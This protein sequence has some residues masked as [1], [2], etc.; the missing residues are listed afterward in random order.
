MLSAQSGDERRRIARAITIALK[1][2]LAFI[3][4][5]MLLGAAIVSASAQLALL[6]IAGGV[7]VALVLLFFQRTRAIGGG[8]LLWGMLAILY[9]IVGY[10]FFGSHE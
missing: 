10:G 5:A 4:D 1:L 3:V 9:L 2:L 7:V 6:I 8:M